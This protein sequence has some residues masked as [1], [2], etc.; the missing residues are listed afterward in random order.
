MSQ[1][2][3]RLLVLD[4]WCSSLKKSTYIW[5]TTGHFSG[6]W[7]LIVCV[8][9]VI[10]FQTQPQRMLLRQDE[11]RNEYSLLNYFAYEYISR[12]IIYCKSSTT[13][14]MVF[15]FIADLMKALFIDCFVHNTIDCMTELLWLWRDTRHVREQILCL[16]S[17]HHDIRYRYNFSHVSKRTWLYDSAKQHPSRVSMAFLQQQ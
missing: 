3:Q 1:Q 13:I 11:V 2:W 15:M 6:W 5:M 14:S 16:V 7:T 9:N 10:G 17:V 12:L 8:S 4:V